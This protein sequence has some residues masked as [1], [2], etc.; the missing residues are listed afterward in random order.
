MKAA[1]RHGLKLRQNY[2]REAPRLALQIGRY[3][4]AKQYKLMRKALRTLRSRVG[5]VMRDVERQLD[6][7]ANH[8]QSNK[9]EDARKPQ[10]PQDHPQVVTGAAWH[11][12]DRV[13][14]RAFEPIPIEF[15]VCLH[16]ADGRL[17]YAAP[18]DHRP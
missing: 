13:T 4:H 3:A 5:Q 17:D 16:M 2:N 8:E 15:A 11:C 18:P 6:P 9:N 12:V 10:L 7:V 14:Q 1:A